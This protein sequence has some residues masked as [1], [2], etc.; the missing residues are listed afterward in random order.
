M[1]G[2]L[3][4]T[5]RGQRLRGHPF[6]TPLRIGAR[7]VAFPRCLLEVLENLSDPSVSPNQLNPTDQLGGVAAVLGH[8]ATVAQLTLD[9]GLDGVVQ[10][11]AALVQEKA[12][13]SWVAGSAGRLP[14]A[15]GSA[16]VSLPQ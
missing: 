10:K 4:S 1:R 5:V 14:G 2:R 6:Q 9:H 13:P 11:R 7:F 8:E 15:P 16:H 3:D 12:G